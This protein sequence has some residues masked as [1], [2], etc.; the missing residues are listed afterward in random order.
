MVAANDG[1][2]SDS[3]VDQFCYSVFSSTNSGTNQ[4]TLAYFLLT[5][6]LEPE[7]KQ[8]H[9]SHLNLTLPPAEEC[10]FAFSNTPQNAADA[11]SSSIML[12]R[13]HRSQ[14]ETLVQSPKEQ[15][16]VHCGCSHLISDIW[17]F[18][19]FTAPNAWPPQG[20]PGSV[21][22]STQHTGSRYL[23]IQ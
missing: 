5:L 19:R 20:Q 22:V 8:Q 11:L 15:F 10:V 13:P 7:H 1:E 6:S 16:S 23:R 18:Q 3:C 2:A 17:N 9:F 14:P 21:C 12:T 4:A